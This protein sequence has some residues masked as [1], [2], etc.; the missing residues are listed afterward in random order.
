MGFFT[1]GPAPA[2]QSSSA[3]PRWQSSGWSAETSGRTRTLAPCCGTNTAACPAEAPPS[4][5]TPAAAPLSGCRAAASTCNDNAHHNDTSWKRASH[6]VKA[7]EPAAGVYLSLRAFRADWPTKMMM[8]K[9]SKRCSR[10]TQSRPNGS[11][12]WI[13]WDSVGWVNKWIDLLCE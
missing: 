5:S 13:P 7:H 6:S 10:R 1:R 8:G 11:T 9:M 3:P 12:Q 4:W 2:T